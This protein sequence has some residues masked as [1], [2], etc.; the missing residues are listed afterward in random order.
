MEQAV[1]EVWIDP[2]WLSWEYRALQSVPEESLGLYPDETP[3]SPRDTTTRLYDIHQHAC[4]RLAS[5]PT[6]FDR[7]DAIIN[8]RRVVA[9]R[10]KTLKDKYQLCEL[11]T[12]QKPRGDLE[13]L[14]YFGII[15]PFMLR[16]L[17]DIRNI[18]EH[19]ASS[20][21]P[22]DECLMFADLIWYFLRSTDKLVHGRVYEVDFE[23]GTSP[24]FFSVHVTFWVS[25]VAQ[26][27]ISVFLKRPQISA[28]LDSSSVSYEPR[29][30]WTRADASRIT[31]HEEEK[32]NPP[33][34]QT[35][36]DVFGNLSCTDE[37]MKQ[38]YGVYF[39]ASHFG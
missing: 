13:L 1:R 39:K 24:E 25:Y 28:F 8:L 23:Q 37:Q 33:L 16:R 7:A 6:E 3:T 10:V 30:N 12:G 34:I 26:P 2:S 36:T 22:T 35:R 17:V 21:P 31:R 29:A 38:I 11:Q 18:V 4:D 20:P 32:I 5:D 27:N 14:S 15:R 19:Q 9:L